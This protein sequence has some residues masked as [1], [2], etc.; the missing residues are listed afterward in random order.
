MDANAVSTENKS[1]NDEQD[2]QL[3][4]RH[5]DLPEELAEAMD[6]YVYV[7]FI[8]YLNLINSNILFHSFCHRTS[9]QNIFNF[10]INL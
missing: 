2:E 9:H 6:M 4:S 1:Q 3:K 5:G 8:V 10:L 7:H